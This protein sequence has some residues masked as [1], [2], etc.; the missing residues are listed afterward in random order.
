MNVP[1]RF[2]IGPGAEPGGA[3]RHENTANVPWEFTTPQDRGGERIT[4]R[5]LVSALTRRNQSLVHQQLALIDQLKADLMDAGQVSAV[6]SLDRLAGKIMRTNNILAALSRDEAE[7]SSA[8]VPIGDVVDAAVSDIEQ[9]ERISVQAPPSARVPGSAGDDLARILAELLDNATS[10]S[11]PETRVTVEITV[12]EGAG[13]RIDL[14][15][16]GIGMTAAELALADAR[17]AGTATLDTSASPPLGLL[18]AGYLAARHNLTV[19]L[20]HGSNG[21]GVR[22][23]VLV[24]AELVT[25]LRETVPIPL[26]SPT[27]PPEYDPP[28]WPA[29]AEPDQPSDAPQWPHQAEHIPAPD[30]LFTH[31]EPTGT[32]LW[33]QPAS[34]PLPY[35]TAAAPSAGSASAVSEL[36]SSSDGLGTSSGAPQETTPIFDEMVSAWFRSSTTS[37]EP[38]S[39]G[40]SGADA[41][42]TGWDS[43]A[44]AGW[45]LV[46]AVSRSEPTS[47]TEA[48]LPRRRRGEQLIPG[49]I[50]PTPGGNFRARDAAGVR[51]RLSDFQRGRDRARGERRG[52]HHRS[53]QD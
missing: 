26:L 9:R 37:T 38:A 32:D 44:D 48:G 19:T 7:S 8:T 17:L 52:R 11:G 21:V 16:Q 47:Y 31:H 15:D 40:E 33:S 10:L 5:E 1:D 50:A 42:S 3:D 18:V 41:N 27:P 46:E 39:L 12:T 45:R 23:S 22:V 49:A 6:F 14:E 53:G 13:L 43:A 25:D 2:G 51:L 34:Q 20:G 29:V 4:Y 28:Q 24:P 35:G 30:E 36:F